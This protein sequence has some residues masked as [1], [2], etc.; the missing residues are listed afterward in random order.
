[1]ADVFT[2]KAVDVHRRSTE[3]APF[4]LYFATHDIHVPRVPHPR[5]VGKSRHGAARRRACSKADWS[6]GQVLDTLDA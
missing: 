1:M 2:G 4:F 3:P 5:F 6:V